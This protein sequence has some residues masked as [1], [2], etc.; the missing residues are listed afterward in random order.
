MQVSDVEKD[1]S[2]RTNVITFS[3]SEVANTLDKIQ[4]SLPSARGAPTVRAIAI[5]TFQWLVLKASARDD[6]ADRFATLDHISEV[7]ITTSHEG[8]VRLQVKFNKFVTDVR[9]K[10]DDA[11]I[12]GQ[13][14]VSVSPQSDTPAYLGRC[15]RIA[16]DPSYQPQRKTSLGTK[17]ASHSF[18]SV[19]RVY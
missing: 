3:G 11:I 6:H 19:E 18:Y 1:I 15:T 5:S 14:Y 17:V 16:L 8:V 7:R 12:D 9:S 10:R 13:A 2:Q 4:T